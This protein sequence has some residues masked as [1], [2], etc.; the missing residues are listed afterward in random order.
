[1][2]ISTL[3]IFILLVTWGLLVTPTAMQAGSDPVKLDHSI[4]RLFQI[5]IL[6]IKNEIIEAHINLLMYSLAKK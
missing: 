3:N 2:K 4:M 6:H 5:Y 1:M